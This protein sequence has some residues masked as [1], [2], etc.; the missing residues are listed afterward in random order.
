M[1]TAEKTLPFRKIRRSLD[2]GRKRFT[3]IELLVV[4]AIIAI[5]ASMLLPSL[6]NARGRAL[7]ATC[8]GNVK[9]LALGARMYV[10]DNDLRYPRHHFDNYMGY[11]PGG[12]YSNTN[13]NFWRYAVIDYVEE[14]DMFLCPTGWRGDAS[15]VNTQLQRCYG[16]S[17]Y[18]NGRAAIQVRDPSQLYMIA[19]ERHWVMNSGNQ[20]WTV[21]YANACGGGCHPERRL[22]QNSRHSGGHNIAFADG[23]VEH[24]RHGE[25]RD[26]LLG[27][28]LRRW[29]FDN[30][31]P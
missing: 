17:S 11:R 16:Y 13:R 2:S 9:Q 4:I 7:T 24:Q 21:A 28:S 18:L 30:V 23:H 14:W 31:M 10:D 22:I 29:H 15:N 8:Q 26:I 6:Q 25:L 20:G 3:L 5:L 12:T 27:N 1:Q 19:D